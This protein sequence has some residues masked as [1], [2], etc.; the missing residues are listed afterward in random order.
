MRD[1]PSQRATTRGASLAHLRGRRS[2]LR[3]RLQERS[4]TQPPG[5]KP[6]IIGEVQID[7]LQPGDW[8]AVAEI[9]RH[10]IAT[11]NATFE[12]E[13]PSWDAWDA[14]HLVGCRFVARSGDDVVGW[15]ALT[16]ISRRSAY[17]GVAEVSVY[18]APAAQNAGVGRALLE[19][20]VHGSEANGIWTLQGAVFPENV[21]SLKLHQACGF[22]V[23]GRRKRIGRLNGVW[24]DVV[25]V[26]RRS[27]IE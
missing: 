8:E 11:E 14:E 6:M 13:V 16:P 27:Q 22:R 26:E 9:Y 12:T 24:R 3:K 17:T 10:G 20:L 23:V 21:T 5:G 18:V 15:A 25:L 4:P 7:D 1:R 19:T 2:L